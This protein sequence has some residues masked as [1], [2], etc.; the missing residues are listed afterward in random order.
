MENSSFVCDRLSFLDTPFDLV[1]MRQVIV[2]LSKKGHRERSFQYVVTPNADHVVRNKENPELI[3]IYENALLSVC[4]SRVV[5]SIARSKGYP[6]NNIITGSDL[7]CRLFKEVI[8]PDKIITIIGGDLEMIHFL[9][10]FYRLDNINHHNP[11]MG[12]IHEE[13]AIHECCEFVAK[14]PSDFVIIAVGSPQ[15][16]ILAA[17]L[18]ETPNCK[19]I[20]LCI[21]ASLLFLTGKETRAPALI[22]RLGIE[23]LYRLMQN[24]RRLWRRYYHNLS[25]FRMVRSEKQYD[26]KTITRLFGE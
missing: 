25:I 8:K 9:Q 10:S 15:Q 17:R 22:S 24:P 7:T 26:G 19:G 12:F 1:S 21:G 13:S 20:G 14:H 5:A 18:K 2:F 4:D 6:I 23:W 11:K 16:E 3:S